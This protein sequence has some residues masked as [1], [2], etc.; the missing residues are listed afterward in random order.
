LLNFQKLEIEAFGLECHV[1]KG[2]QRTRLIK[3]AVAKYGGIDILVSNAAVNPVFCK[4][5]EVR[6]LNQPS[7]LH[8]L[9]LLIFQTPEEGWDK[10][11]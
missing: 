9:F 2:D 8:F 7:S 6:P 5:L 3:E 11:T 10:V 1:A 4:T